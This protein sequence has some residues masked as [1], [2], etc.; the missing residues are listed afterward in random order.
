ASLLGVSG[1]SVRNFLRERFPRAPEA[2]GTRYG[3]LLPDQLEAIFEHF[4][5]PSTDP[6]EDAGRRYEAFLVLLDEIVE[7][8]A[9]RGVELRDRLDAQSL[10]WWITS[11][12]PPADWSEED[13]EAF[14]MYQGE[15]ADDGGAVS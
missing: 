8:M 12:K 3:P 2:K 9:S 14:L 1:L 13:K 7:R 11:A 6:I 5:R 4:G 15:R 10:A